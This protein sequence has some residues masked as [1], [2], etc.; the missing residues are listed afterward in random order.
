MEYQAVKDNATKQGLREHFQAWCSTKLGNALFT[1]LVGALI[2]YGASAYMPAEALKAKL[3][4]MDM[5]DM[6]G[7]HE[8][9]VEA[10]ATPEAE[11]PKT[12]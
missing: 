8:L 7:G 2:G 5:P 1:L 12:P 3:M 6:S 4:N 11:K 10:G 9:N